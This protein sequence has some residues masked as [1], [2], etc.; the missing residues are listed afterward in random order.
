[1]VSSLTG[2]TPRLS[3]SFQILTYTAN[4]LAYNPGG[5]NQG[6]LFWLAWAFH[7][8]NSVISLGDAHG[9]IGRAQVLMNCYGAQAVPA[10]ERAVG[11]FG[12]CPK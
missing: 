3:Q 11:A 4:E 6:F 1:V 2:T 10:F 5:R 8:F 12:L 7:N 9:G